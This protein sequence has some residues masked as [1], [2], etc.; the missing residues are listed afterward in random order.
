VI[1]IATTFSHS[2]RIVFSPSG[3]VAVLYSAMTNQAQVVTGLPGGPQLSRTV[4]SR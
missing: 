1:P 4:V 2:D 3:S